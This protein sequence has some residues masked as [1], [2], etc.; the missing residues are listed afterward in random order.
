MEI[1]NKKLM[2]DNPGNYFDNMFN[3]YTFICVIIC[4]ANKLINIK[5]TSLTERCIPHH[6]SPYLW[7]LHLFQSTHYV[8]TL[9]MQDTHMH[10]SNLS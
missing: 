3:V 7:D 1:C 2:E 6:N 10:Q 8:S 9:V 4:Y 5:I